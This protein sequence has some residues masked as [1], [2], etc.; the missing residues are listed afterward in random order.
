MMAILD[1]IHTLG[2]GIEHSKRDGLMGTFVRAVIYHNI[3]LAQGFEQ[4]SIGLIPDYNFN[5]LFLKALAIGVYVK[6]DN[7][8]GGEITLPKLQRAAMVYA[9]LKHSADAGPA[10]RKVKIVN[11]TVML[12]FVYLPALV[13][14]Q[15]LGERDAVQNE[16]PKPGD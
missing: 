10:A 1:Q 5:P 2:L 6:S 15:S 12:P 13:G 7:S 3:K 11:P 8:C 16:F 9:D 4:P 14:T